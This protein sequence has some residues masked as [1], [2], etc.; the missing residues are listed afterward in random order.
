MARPILITQTKNAHCTKSHKEL[1]PLTKHSKF[2]TFTTENLFS[3]SVESNTDEQDWHSLR[4][5]LECGPAQPS[6]KLVLVS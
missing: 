4:D 3:R 6:L 2:Q 1:G 5:D